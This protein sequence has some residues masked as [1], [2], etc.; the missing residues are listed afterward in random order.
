MAEFL[1]KTSHLQKHVIKE[2]LFDIRF[3]KINLANVLWS[4]F[5][6]ESQY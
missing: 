5:T 3:A 4:Q 6:I 1:L 2:Y